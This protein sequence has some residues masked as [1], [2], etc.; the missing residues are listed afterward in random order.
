MD[1]DGPG[2]HIPEEEQPIVAGGEE[3]GAVVGE[4]GRA[5][6]LRVP[7]VLRSEEVIGYVDDRLCRVYR[8]GGVRGALGVCMMYMWWCIWCIYVI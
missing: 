2:S 3:E 8:G 1:D 6:R 5:D 7:P 4:H